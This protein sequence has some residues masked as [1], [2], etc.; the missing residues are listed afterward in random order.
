MVLRWPLQMCIKAPPGTGKTRA[1]T[2]RIMALLDAGKKVIFA[3]PTHALGEQIVRDLEAIGARVYRSRG[4]P[5]PMSADGLTM[6]LEKD[7][8][9]AIVG[10]LG[11]AEKDACKRGTQICD[12]Y[13]GCGFQ[14]QKRNPPRIWVVAH[15]LLYL[16]LPD[17][18]P[19]PDV[20]VIDESFSTKAL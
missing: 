15:E 11:D 1:I 12:F 2:D 13:E 9:V 3:V 14:R 8:T 7:R 5:D 18:I 4:A 10:A 16:A 19:A 20:V 6:C 17:F